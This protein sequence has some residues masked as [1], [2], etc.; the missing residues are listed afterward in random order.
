[1]TTLLLLFLAAAPAY[2]QDRDQANPN[3][4]QEE[5]DKTKD[6]VA[7]PDEGKPGPEQPTGRPDERKNDQRKVEAPKQND[8][9]QP[10]G[11]R[12]QEQRSTQEM[13]R[14]NEQ[15]R[16]QAQRG[17]RIPDNKFRASFGRQHAFHVRREQVVNNPQPIVV[18]GGYSFELVES[19]PAEW[20]FDD[21]VYVDYVGDG[22]YL[23]D[24]LHPGIRIAVIVVE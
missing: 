5:K 15:R 4:Q 20:A 11:A 10:E 17:K 21:D 19:W 8:N 18:Y 24:V 9:R 6:K 13:D 16:T 22:Y 23:F 2:P 1:M 14:G 3:Q 12:P 7:K